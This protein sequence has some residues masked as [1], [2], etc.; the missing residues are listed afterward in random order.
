MNK[1]YFEDLAG[2][3]NWA[4]KK[5]IDYLKQID[6]EQWNLVN[7]SSFS[8]IRQTAIHIASAEK[9]WG[10]FW[11]RAKK[12]VYLSAVFNGTRE[13]LISIWETASAGLKQFIENHSEEN[14]A[15]PVA[16]IY[17]DGRTGTMPYWQTFAH[18]V[19]HSTYHRG[20]LVT[21]LRQAGCKEFSNM[22]LATYYL[23]NKI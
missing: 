2:F 16:F 22:D 13:E 1:K 18:I 9:I 17:P 8:S 21:L 3:N 11:T 14:L 19:N 15:Q 7:I 5:A 10:D 4:D 23:T 20:Q 12:P 6:D